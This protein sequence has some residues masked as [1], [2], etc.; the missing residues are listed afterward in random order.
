MGHC[1]N[2]ACYRECYVFQTEGIFF[3]LW[4]WGTCCMKFL[5]LKGKSDGFPAVSSLYYL[6]IFLV[7]FL[8]YRFFSFCLLKSIPL[9][10]FS[11]IC[12]FFNVDCILSPSF[13]VHFMQNQSE[14]SLKIKKQKGKWLF[15]LIFTFQIHFSSHWDY[16][17][18]D[19]HFLSCL[20]CLRCIWSLLFMWLMFWINETTQVFWP[21]ENVTVWLRSTTLMALMVRHLSTCRTVKVKSSQNVTAHLSTGSQRPYNRIIRNNK[22]KRRQNKK[23]NQTYQ[24]KKEGENGRGK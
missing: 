7:S 2:T 6:V 4:G 20:H 1:G 19:Y 17:F 13:S 15:E 12:L 10:C 14:M 5:M 11:W 21:V 18:I 23:Q 24:T 22:N 8:I 9:F 16:N 3:F